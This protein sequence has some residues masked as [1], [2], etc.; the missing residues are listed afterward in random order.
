MRHSHAQHEEQNVWVIVCYFLGHFQNRLR[1]DYKDNWRCYDNSNTIVRTAGAAGTR[2]GKRIATLKKTQSVG[3][4]TRINRLQKVNMADDIE[5]K[6]IEQSPVNEKKQKKRKDKKKKDVDETAS[7]ENDAESETKQQQDDEKERKKKKKDKKKKKH[8]EDVTP[9]GD[10]QDNEPKGE[11]EEGQHREKKK[12]DKKKK[13]DEEAPTSTEQQSKDVE[14]ERPRSEIS[15]NDKKKDKKRKK[16]ERKQENATDN[17]EG[18]PNDGKAATEQTEIDDKEKQE[19]NVKEANKKDK[20][21]KKKKED[22]VAQE[23]ESNDANNEEMTNEQKKNNKEDKDNKKKDKKSKYDENNVKN[24]TQMTFKNN[25]KSPVSEEGYQKVLLLAQTFAR[26]STI[27]RQHNLKI[28]QTNDVLSKVEAVLTQLERTQNT[29]QFIW[30]IENFKEHFLAARMGKKMVVYCPK[31]ESHHYGYHIGI[32]LCPNGDG[33]GRVSL[34]IGT[35]DVK[36][37]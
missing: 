35:I 20:K 30:K 23:S 22:N 7:P 8:E 17:S 32:T 26:V 1:H 15:E 25:T 5:E 4:L 34:N 37:N 31:V 9:E 21:K 29:Y 3:T 33:V 18:I 16:K 13:K 19:G 36:P 2:P 10:G 6:P 14:P 12:K 28:S 11:P 24:S 27:A